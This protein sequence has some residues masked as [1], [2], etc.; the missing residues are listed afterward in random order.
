MR[1]PD[2]AFSDHA[3]PEILLHLLHWCVV[4]HILVIG[5]TSRVHVHSAGCVLMLSMP[6]VKAFVAALV[7]DLMVFSFVLAAFALMALR[8]LTFVFG[9]SC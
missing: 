7:H 4:N 3:Q 2:A 1:T 6:P 5:V 9:I 8:A